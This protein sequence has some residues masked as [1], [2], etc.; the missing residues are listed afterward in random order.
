CSKPFRKFC[1]KCRG[2]SMNAKLPCDKTAIVLAVSTDPVSGF[3]TEYHSL[4]DF[5]K[6]CIDE[7]SFKVKPESFICYELPQYNCEGCIALPYVNP[8]QLD[9]IVGYAIRGIAKKYDTNQIP[10]KEI[11]SQKVSFWIGK[12]GVFA[13][14]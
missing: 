12:A 6:G 1:D 8:Q 4:E 10:H 7:Q 9:E 14:N 11:D 5:I 3:K 2:Y 13:S